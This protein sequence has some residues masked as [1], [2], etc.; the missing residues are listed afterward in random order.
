M[1]V[2]C[3]IILKGSGGGESRLKSRP[4]LP[5]VEESVIEAFIF[6]FL[7]ELFLSFTCSFVR[8]LSH[9]L[10]QHDSFSCCRV[11]TCEWLAG[12]PQRIMTGDCKVY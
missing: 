12:W 10:A 5:R 1:K 2:N 6:Y 11:I 9:S 7:L 8:S 3:T 4:L